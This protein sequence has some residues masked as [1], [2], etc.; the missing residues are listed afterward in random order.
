M[1]SEPLALVRRLCIDECAD[2]APAEYDVVADT[3]DMSSSPALRFLEFS[4][5]TEILEEGLTEL[6]NEPVHDEGAVGGVK[7]GGL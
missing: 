1:V 3:M 7:M 4:S 6:A 5:R 2:P